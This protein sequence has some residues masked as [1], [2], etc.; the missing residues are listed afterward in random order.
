MHARRQRGYL[1][2]PVAV[3]IAVIAAIALLS[4]Y[5]SSLE[6]NT[7][8]IEQDARRALY[9]A[10][11]GFAHGRWLAAQQGCGPYTDLSETLGAD[12]YDTKLT[13]DLGT[14]A[15]YTLV[16]DH[17]AW[18]DGGNPGAN[19]GTDA[20]LHLRFVG[21]ESERPVYRYDLSPLPANAT[22][23]SATAWFF[24]S[25]EHPEGPVNIHRLTADWTESDATWSSLGDRMDPDIL[26][27]IPAQPDSDVWVAVNLTAQLQAWVNG[28][29]N[30]GITFDSQS[31]GTDGE[32][33]S[34]EGVN[35]PFITVVVGTPPS[36]LATLKAKAKLANGVS[37]SVMREDLLLT[38]FPQFLE[39]QPDGAAGIDAALSEAEP[40]NNYGTSDRFWV[41]DASGADD[42]HGLL[43]FDLA[44]VPHGARI[45]R[46]ELELFQYWEDTPGGDIGIYRVRRDWQE[47]NNDGSP[48]TGAS[49]NMATA[50]EGWSTNGGERDA[51][52]V[53]V[54]AITPGT[55]GYYRWDITPLVQGWVDGSLPNDGMLI[56]PQAPG[57]DA[58]FRSSDH[59]VAAER[60]KL[61]LTYACACGI[62]CV[63]ATGA[64]DILFVVG[65]EWNLTSREREYVELF[66][67]L[68]YGV[69]L[70]SDYD[71][72]WNFD[73]KAANND[74]IFVSRNVDTGEW[75]LVDKIR[76]TPRGVLLDK[77]N[78]LDDIGLA[79]AVDMGVGRALENVDA[80][81]DITRVFAGDGD[82]QIFDG[83]MDL[84]GASGSAPGAQ[85]LARHHGADALLAID[86][87][88]PLGGAL[89]GQNAAGRRVMLPFVGSSGFNL[90]A[91]NHNGRVLLQRAL[92]W[93]QYATCTPQWDS[94]RVAAGADDA[95]QNFS[96]VTID[97]S[98]LELVRD[99]I[100]NQTVGIRFQGVG[101][102]PGGTIVEAYLD[103]T[104]DETDSGATSITIE[105][106]LSA[107]AAA[108]VETGND[109]TDRSRT[110]A[111]VPWT[112]IPA[113]TTVGEV[114][115]SPDVSP[116]LR[117]IV[118]GAGWAAGNALAF[119]ITG[120]GTR[121]AEAY[122][123]S[124]AQAPLLR[125]AFCGGVPVTP[126][127]LMVV[128][129]DG[130]LTAQEDA[131]KI[132]FESWGYTVNLIDEDDPQ[133]DFD[134][135]VAINDVAFIGEDVT[136][137][138]LN[139]KLV[140]AGI[141]VVT[142]EANLAD[143]FGFADA[144]AWGSGTSIDVDLL[145]HIT[146]TI[147]LG[148][149]TIL[150]TTESLAALDGLLAPDLQPLA[151]T[152]DGTALA[153]LDAGAT[154]VGGGD[155][156]G[157]RVFLPW[158]GNDMDVNH[159]SADG[160]TILRRA[161]EWAGGTG[162]GDP[163]LPIAHWKLDETGGLTAIDSAGGND[164]TLVGGPAWTPGLID[165]GL[166]FDGGDDYVDA[167]TFDVGGSGITMMGWFNADTIA[168]DDP[169]IVSK[170]S[171][172]NETDAWWQLSTT[173]SGPDRFLRMRIKAGGTTT[174]LAD[175][176]TS[177]ATGAWHFAVAT[178]DAGS[179][180]MK[181]YLD[182]AEVASRSHTVGG[183]LDTAP[184]VPVALG[185]NGTAE[186]F[187]D[188]RLDD[189]R[190][191][192]YALDATAIA[193]L[194]AADAPGTPG[195]TELHA[196]WS[197]TAVDT[198]EPVDLS[199]F[200]VPANAVVE[201]AV[202]NADDGKQQW[203]GARAMGSTLD[204]RFQLH[205][206][207]S[208]GVDAITLH[209]QADAAG[210]IE[211]YSSK[212]GDV[213]FVL[214]GYWTGATYVERFDSFKA[215][216]SASWRDVSL[217]GFGVGADQVAEIAAVNDNTGSERYAGLRRNGS[218]LDRRLALHEAESGGIDAGAIWVATDAGATIE[219]FAESDGDID[220]YL[221]GYW[222][223]PPG[224]FTE[225][226][227]ILPG[228][229]ASSG[230]WDNVDLSGLGLPADAVAQI[231]LANTLT[232]AETE[233]GVREVG[234]SLDRVLDLQEAESGGNDFGT[235]HVV[236]DAA[237]R[238]EW[239]DEQA[240]GGLRFLLTGWWE[241]VP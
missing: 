206:P 131:K 225:A 174:T 163:T 237:A 154:M 13:T 196:P 202:L 35:K 227:A 3:M 181:L 12:L 2:L 15:S 136:A 121:T 36:P 179:A 63:P 61:T 140:S 109:I 132:L 99:S 133:I 59:A 221:L 135:A 70:L 218:G 149:H 187:F 97:S 71:V 50:S 233:M 34:K 114:H 216:A 29:P 88:E 126:Q 143:E 183:V 80:A 203:G 180:E 191:Y 168:S 86:A 32:Y 205:E 124:P 172:T 57:T 236:A 1:L 199:G 194:Y 175:S 81:H 210:R 8:V 58:G 207:E 165:G 9:V 90:A 48:G 108:Y 30:Q 113:W 177:L 232:G 26:V 144:I 182:G 73:S 201:V 115:T 112:N 89:A 129:N 105:G 235:M 45:I 24:I 84:R 85:V 17:D 147:G 176:T 240:V 200:G 93:A 220:F 184:A 64:G 94:W 14:T 223:S 23:L 173:D 101:I 43:R 76:D 56:Y 62:A 148:T 195:Y 197:A 4:N 219:A 79:A 157:R 7:T 167:G 226:A 153:A 156:A 22:I 192:N 21:G 238:I 102:P 123:G 215:G 212:T 142:E 155:T 217:T 83:P 42:D 19:N 139:T 193:D 234:S 128:G 33:S 82:L 162:A 186:R 55:T 106:E 75:G 127:L 41:Y 211:H 11:A 170:A 204:R 60:P 91:V 27:S 117:E 96:V 51:S 190:I 160:L 28:E 66:G 125:V 164:G 146:E 166:A 44:R 120:N 189:V 239:Y 53:A 54:T 111:S 18:L 16:T 145:H 158:G 122:D 103:F 222:N 31:E 98:D 5:E 185:A 47:G 110:T 87:G 92:D 230:A 65:N 231:L 46:A 138:D 178:Y 241:L 141:G 39:L 134:A 224:S 171:G 68:G 208:G 229:P 49:W 116:L 214:L 118:N 74:V 130:G 188:G 20:N 107:D 67:R 209:V 25:K 159:L 228:A 119:I 198:W 151:S 150:T 38:Q 40:N 100:V 152:V 169:R 95:E 213:T 137:A 6:T 72:W 37:R 10:E 52:P 69:D 161:L 78:M 104:T 77:Q